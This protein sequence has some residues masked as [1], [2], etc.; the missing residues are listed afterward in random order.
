[1]DHKKIYFSVT[2]EIRYIAEYDTQCFETKYIINTKTN[3]K[4]YKNH[5]KKTPKQTNEK[6]SIIL[7]NIL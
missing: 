4:E 3:K 6:K 2:V 5:K 1:M 7:I